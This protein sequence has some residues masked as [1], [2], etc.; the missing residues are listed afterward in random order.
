MTPN[1]LLEDW[2]EGM[3][4][5]AATGLLAETSRSSWVDWLTMCISSGA[6]PPAGCTATPSGAVPKATCASRI[7]M[8]FWVTVA[9]V[10]A[11][12]W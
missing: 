12:A 1:R 10:A 3:E 9:P 7:A 8:P 11:F 6:V 2:L 5:K 4:S